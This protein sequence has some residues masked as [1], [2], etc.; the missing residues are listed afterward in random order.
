[1]YFK[2]HIAIALTTYYAVKTTSPA[3]IK[4]NKN[5]LNIKQQ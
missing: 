3:E 1:M 2:Q 5:N 4:T